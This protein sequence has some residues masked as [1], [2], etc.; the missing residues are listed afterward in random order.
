MVTLE[1]IEA[2][3]TT[4]VAK[5]LK[6]NKELLEVEKRNNIEIDALKGGI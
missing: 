6:Q 5:L 3:L 2:Y 1:A 4:K